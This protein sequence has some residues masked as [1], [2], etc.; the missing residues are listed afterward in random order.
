MKI[1]P[2]VKPFE[3]VLKEPEQLDYTTRITEDGYVT[4]QEQ[5][6]RFMNAGDLIRGPQDFDTDNETELDSD[7]MQPVYG[8]DPVETQQQLDYVSH[9]LEEKYKQPEPEPVQPTEPEKT[10]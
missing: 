8:A 7:M 6:T 4:I 10:E 9:K 2:C 5:V 1:A 3:D